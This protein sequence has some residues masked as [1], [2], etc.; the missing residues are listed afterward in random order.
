MNSSTT[1]KMHNRPHWTGSTIT[2]G[3][4]R[5]QIEYTLGAPVSAD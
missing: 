5:V 4:L 1:M 2:S 3:S